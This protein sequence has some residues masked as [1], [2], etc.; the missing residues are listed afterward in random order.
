MVSTVSK[1]SR[2]PWAFSLLWPRHLWDLPE[3]IP[4]TWVL[5]AC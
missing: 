1:S 4:E 2:L 5:G 3:Q